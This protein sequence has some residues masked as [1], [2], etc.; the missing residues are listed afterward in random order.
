MKRF[1]FFAY[2]VL[3]YTFFLG[4]FLYAVG[5]V[6]NFRFEPW[7]GWVFVPRSMDLGGEAG[8][9]GQALLVDALL[10]GLFALQHSG[11]ARRGFKQR[12]TRVVPP[13]IER[14]T[15]VL[16]SSA[17]LATLL[18][19]WRPLGF[20]VWAASDPSVQAALVVAS[21]AGWLTALA[22]TFHIDHFS[23]F[24]LR[25]TWS[26]LRGREVP[27]HRFVTPGLYRY[28]RH[29]LYLGFLVAFWATPVMTL[30]HLVF[31]LATTGYILVAIQLEER[32]LVREYG[33][34]YLRYRQQVPMLTPLPR[35]PEPAPEAK[36]E[37]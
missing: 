30:G 6:G 13:V 5:F 22:A 17:A 14:S 29:P 25:Q 16:F 26:A 33:P 2:S 1:V 20:A 18:A 32:D 23:L 27:A 35:R 4:T 7:P 8:P 24:G 36:L 21:L 31:A 3:A 9:V 19:F 34:D 37:P 12:W 28:V 10:L 11:M 15:Y